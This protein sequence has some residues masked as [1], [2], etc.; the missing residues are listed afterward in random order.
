MGRG[1]RV[2]EVGGGEGVA[3][4][5][6]G[7]CP[8]GGGGGCGGAGGGAA[9]ELIVGSCS[10]AA[11]TC[12]PQLFALPATIVVTPRQRGRKREGWMDGWK[13]RMMDRRGVQRRGRSYYRI[14]SC[15]IH[16]SFIHPFESIGR[17]SHLL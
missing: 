9:H 1:G 11:I 13:D 14:Q 12:W 16:S 4:A 8:R 2:G 3:G 10:P 6:E 7:V 5:V 15:P 17:A